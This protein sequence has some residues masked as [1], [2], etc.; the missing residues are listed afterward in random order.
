MQITII[1]GGNLGH[2]IAGVC[3]SKG[4]KTNILT[5]R[6]GNWSKELVISDNHNRKYIGQLNII[7]DNPSLVIPDSDIIILC[8]PGNLI[9]KHIKRIESYVRKDCYVGSI[10]SSSGF[11]WIA[12]SILGENS[13]LFGF[14]RVPFIS[15]IL[16]YGKSAK[17]TGYKAIHKMAFSKNVKPNNELRDFFE[18]ILETKI[19]TLSNYLEAALTNSNPILHPSRMYSLFKDRNKDTIIEKE[20]LFYEEWSLDSSEILIHADT[21]F[22]NTV[23]LL[24]IDK[25]QM[26]SLLEY[27]ECRNAVELTAKIRSIEAFKGIKVPMLSVENGYIPDLKNRYFIEDIPYG[28]LIIKSLGI[29]LNQR[30]PTIDTLIFWAQNVLNKKYLKDLNHF[31]DDIV[32]SGIPQNYGIHSISDLL[33][34]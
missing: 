9:E 5:D 23:K 10:V 25:T 26:P 11:F 4:V 16:E 33:K 28:I 29:L 31:D 3:S 22:E 14:Q 32:Y 13:N 20:Y 27:Y 15:R 30:T 24:P 12:R 19:V 1:G 18:F 21:E 7:T 17:I 34:I 6:P 2:V 8:L